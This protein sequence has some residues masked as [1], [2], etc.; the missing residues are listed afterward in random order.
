MNT[1][2][3]PRLFVCHEGLNLRISLVGQ[4]MGG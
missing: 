2:S 1:S 4:F 3:L